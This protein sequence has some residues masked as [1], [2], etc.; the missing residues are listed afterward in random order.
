MRLWLLLLL[1][2]LVTT[3]RP[4][5]PSAQLLFTVPLPA[6]TL[7]TVWLPP[8]TASFPRHTTGNKTR[9]GRPHPQGA[10]DHTDRRVEVK[11]L[12]IIIEL[13]TSALAVFVILT[14]VCCIL[15]KL[16]VWR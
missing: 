14:L 15:Q 6:P 11:K 12:E 4:A 9:P 16:I 2:G 7:I 1:G 5:P 3:L 10:G 8:C 13:V